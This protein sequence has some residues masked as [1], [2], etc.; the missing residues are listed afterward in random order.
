MQFY[1]TALTIE[2]FCVRMNDAFQL[3]CIF[4][5]MHK[6]VSHFQDSFCAFSMLSYSKFIIGANSFQ[7]LLLMLDGWETRWEQK[8]WQIQNFRSPFTGVKDRFLPL[9]QDKIFY[10]KK[11][12]RYNQAKDHNLALQ[13]G[14]WS[15]MP[16]C[17]PGLDEVRHLP[18]SKACVMWHPTP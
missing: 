1:S 18:S 12:K 15:G 16:N 17:F 3:T 6:T 11:K 8:A 7:K 10:Q 9:R 2:F 5:I 14:S 13:I 4:P